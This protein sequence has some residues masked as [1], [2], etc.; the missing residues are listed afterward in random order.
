MLHC[1]GPL[2]PPEFSN[3]VPFLDAPSHLYKRSCPSVRRSVCPSVGSSRVIIEGE[4]YAV[5]PALLD[6][7]LHLNKKGSPSVHDVQA[8]IPISTKNGL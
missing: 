2:F 1:L 4:K 5:Y 8:E 6:A 7:F 3:F